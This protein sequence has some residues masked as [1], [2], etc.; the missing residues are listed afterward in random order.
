MDAV[1]HS[2]PAGSLGAGSRALGRND[3]GAAVKL[4]RRAVALL[5]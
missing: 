2:A 5:P 1:S 3:V 4:L